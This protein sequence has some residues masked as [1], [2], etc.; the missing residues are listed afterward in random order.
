MIITTNKRKIDG[1]IICSKCTLSK[2]EE[3]GKIDHLVI[4]LP[5]FTKGIS[6]LFIK[7]IC[8]ANDH[9]AFTACQ[10]TKYMR[11]SLTQIFFMHIYVYIH[12]NMM[13]VL[14]FRPALLLQLLLSSYCS[15][16]ISLFILFTRSCTA[17]GFLIKHT[18]EYESGNSSLNAS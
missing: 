16:P 6:I 15:R 11:G 4:F 13:Q 12:V 8:V 14:S 7:E 2:K 5:S 18:D 10:I 17:N 3:D 9:V 1:R